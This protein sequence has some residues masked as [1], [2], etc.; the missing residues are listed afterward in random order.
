MLFCGLLP[1]DADDFEKRE[2]ISRL[3]LNDA[4]FTP[5]TETSP[6]S[7]GPSV[8]FA[9]CQRMLCVGPA[10]VRRRE[11]GGGLGDQSELMETPHAPRFS[12]NGCDHAGTCP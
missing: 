10:Q 6:R 4:S 2:P 1:V 9:A 3:R 11:E 8:C 5:K 12:R 7:G